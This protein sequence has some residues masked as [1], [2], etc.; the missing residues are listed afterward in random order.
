MKVKNIYKLL[1]NFKFLFKIKTNT[2]QCIFEN[3]FTE[4][5]HNIQ[6][7]L[8]RTVLS[9]EQLCIQPSKIFRLIMRTKTLEQT[10]RPTT[11]ISGPRNLL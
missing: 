9:K 8:V 10:I 6:I 4:I 5:Q 11:K 7:N 2:A 3:R 1:L